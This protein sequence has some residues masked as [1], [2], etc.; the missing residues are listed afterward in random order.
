MPGF[1]FAL[2]GLSGALPALERCVSDHLQRLSLDETGRARIAQ[3][4]DADLSRYVSDGDYPLFMV[5]L[6]ISGTVRAR[7][8]V[9]AD[10]AVIDCYINQ[11]SGNAPLDYMT[12]QTLS[13]AK[14]TPAKDS[15]GRAVAG[16]VLQTIVWRVPEERKKAR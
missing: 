2:D 9:G 6:G 3:P 4:P 16:A 13:R 15:S 10:G 14:F 12:C 11:S 7:L 5:G 1:E 8:L